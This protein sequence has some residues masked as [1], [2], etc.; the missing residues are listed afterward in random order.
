MDPALPISIPVSR[1]WTPLP[2]TERSLPATTRLPALWTDTK[3]AF[4]PR[5]Y[6]LSTSF[7]PVATRYPPVFPPSW[8]LRSTLLR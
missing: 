5:S 2:P 3:A 8:L 7:H 6:F 1:P 4:H